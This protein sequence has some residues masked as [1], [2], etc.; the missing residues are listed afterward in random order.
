MAISSTIKKELTKQFGSNDKDTG[1]VKVQIAI[2][3]KEIA[4]L[5]KHLQN[6][7]KDLHSKSSIYEKSSARFKLLTYLKA[8]NLKEY[9]KLIKELQIRTI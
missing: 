4:Q 8:T 9:N 6:A 5:T 3:T 1:N 7:K 2:L